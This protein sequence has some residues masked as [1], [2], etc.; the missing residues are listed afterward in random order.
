MRR[1]LDSDW[2]RYLWHRAGFEV[3]ATVVVLGLAAVG[4]GGFF[5]FRA[6]SANASTPAGAY[7]QI[8][9]TVEKLVR[10]REKGRVVVK[11]VPVVKRV[12][13]QPVTEM[14]TRYETASG[15]TVVLTEPVVRYRPVYR[16]KVVTVNGKS[17][18]VVQPV[19]NT[20]MLTETQ[21]L[22][23]TNE[24]VATV[25]Q[26]VTNQQ[27]ATVRETR[28]ATQTQFQTVTQPVTVENDVTVT[29]PVTV[30]DES[31]VTLPAETVTVTVPVTVTGGGSGGG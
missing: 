18:T 28:T 13:A 7:V 25:V 17:V 12:Y 9:T 26:N 6:V 4:V 3:Q 2:Y 14:R 23:V 19:T 5:A 1:W 31:T 8:A 22:T 24:R 21:Q 15:S 16:K 20:R 29:Q 27:T 10:V 11:R 30:T